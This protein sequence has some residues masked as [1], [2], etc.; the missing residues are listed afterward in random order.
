MDRRVKRTRVAVFNA[1]MELLIEKDSSKITVL[2][3]CKKADINKSTFYLHYKSLD[4]CLEYCFKMI[5]NGVVEFAKAINYE[6]MKVNPEPVINRILDE[7]EKNIDYFYRF[8]NSSICANG[9]RV[10]KENLVSGIAEFN[11]FNINNDYEK[12]TSIV[13]IVGGCFDA[14]IEPLPIFNKEE[15]SK[16]ICTIIKRR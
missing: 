15:L 9:L 14:I 7:L 10:I 5:L 2:E 11:G 13:F 1:L 6:E 4:D 8:K 16:T 12:Y 3:L